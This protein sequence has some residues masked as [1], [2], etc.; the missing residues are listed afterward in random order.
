M[1]SWFLTLHYFHYIAHNTMLVTHN[2]LHITLIIIRYI[3]SFCHI[4]IDGTQRV[5]S[6]VRNLHAL[7]PL[8]VACKICILKHGRRRYRIKHSGHLR[9]FMKC[10]KQSAAACVFYISV[11]FSNTFCHSA[12]H[13]LAT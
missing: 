10:G 12:I 2:S 3:T 11:L 5:R 1:F 13:D 8:L 7:L 6:C 9:T 4:N